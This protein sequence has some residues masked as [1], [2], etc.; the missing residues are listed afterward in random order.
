MKLLTQIRFL[1]VLLMG[2]SAGLITGLSHMLSPAR[3]HSLQKSWA[4]LHLMVT[5]PLPA[6]LIVHV[7]SVY[8]F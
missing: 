1:T 3:A 7:L 4:F 8:F 6:L 5:W 2:A